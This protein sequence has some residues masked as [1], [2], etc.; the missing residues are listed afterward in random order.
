MYCRYR[1]LVSCF[2]VLVSIGFCVIMN[3]SSKATPAE[4]C[5][6]KYLVDQQGIF[7]F[8]ILFLCFTASCVRRENKREKQAAVLA[9][10]GNISTSGTL[11]SVCGHW[12]EWDALNWGG[13]YP[14]E[15][16]YQSHLCCKGSL[17][18]H[19]QILGQLDLSL[20]MW[21]GGTSF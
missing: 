7:F 3:K 14:V 20:G 2:S 16:I 1:Y 11:D 10:A 9:T 12:L 5:T 8:L 18:Q 17:P 19:M 6:E 21:G 13:V 4:S 15:S